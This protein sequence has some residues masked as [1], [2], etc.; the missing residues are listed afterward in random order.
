MVLLECATGIKKKAI[1][2]PVDSKELK[3]IMKSKKFGFDWNIEA[4][5]LVY[6]I[7]IYGSDE[8]LGLMSL[9][10]FPEEKWIKINLLESSSE[11]IGK[12]KKYEYISG[13]LIAFACKKSFVYGYYGAVGL[14]P[15]TRLKKHYID[16]FGFIERGLH[17]EIE[18][19]LSDALI[20]NYL[21]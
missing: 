15:K 9:I 10:D 16:K 17:P 11:N 21:N 18:G 2:E 20:K 12:S 14:L 3:I 6:K 7:R 4:G 1:I 19:T 13:C 5:N 8:V